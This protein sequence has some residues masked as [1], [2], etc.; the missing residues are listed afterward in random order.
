MP[1]FDIVSKV[2]R[3]ELDNALNQA[4]KEITQ[5]FDFRGTDTS[6]ESSEAGI[7][8][9]ANSEGR[10]EAAWEVLLS[11]LVRREV[12]PECIERGKIEAASGQNVRQ[13]LTI[14]E[15]ISQD[16]ARK[17]TRLVKDEKLKVQ[18]AIQGDQLRV[19]GKKR[20]DL[21]AAIAAIRG[22]NLGLALQYTNFRD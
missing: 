19:T 14:K 20:D 8:L 16:D 10:I 7:T 11:K 2:D 12:P 5:R 6:I 22:A 18:A 13:L 17:I 9:K 4:R 21:Q 1:S 15:G 3:Q